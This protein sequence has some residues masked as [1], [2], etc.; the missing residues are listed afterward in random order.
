LI[1]PNE[2]AA[3]AFAYTLGPEYL[4]WASA[5]PSSPTAT[6]LIKG[7]RQYLHILRVMEDN[8]VYVF[9]QGWPVDQERMFDKPGEYILATVI[10]G[11]GVA[12]LSPYRLKLIITGDWKEANMEAIN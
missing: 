12:T 4:T 11:D 5:H 7:V 3:F 9:A 8:R 6:R 2:C 1:T 10:S